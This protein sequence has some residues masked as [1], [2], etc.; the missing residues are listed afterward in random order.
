VQVVEEEIVVHELTVIALLNLCDLLLSDLQISGDAEVLKGVQVYQSRLLKIAENQHSFWLLAET[1][2]LQ[3]KIL[4]LNLN[5]EEA[6]RLLTLAQRFADEK[7]LH[8][9]AARISNEHDMLLEELDIWDEMTQRKTP[10]IER[11]NLARI[12][13]QVENMFRQSAMEDLDPVEEEPIMLMVLSGNGLLVYSKNFALT[14]EMSD[15]MIGNFL[16]AVQKFGHEVFS[17]ALD[18]IKFETYTVLIRSKDP[19]TFCY[20]YNGQSYTAQQKL[21]E[22]IDDVLSRS[23]VWD[24]LLD[25]IKTGG[26]LDSDSQTTLD[27]LLSEVFVGP[28]SN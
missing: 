27:V 24:T 14:A 3:S 13:N 8:R 23:D 12:D 5:V 7:G 22:L 21:S 18:R 6:R 10:Y 19:L 16:Q 17:Q 28:T 4:L 11:S 25:P 20:I 2:V 15:R 9:Q 26:A 1:F